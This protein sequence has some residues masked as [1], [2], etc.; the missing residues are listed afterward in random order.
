MA[1][2][3][4]IAKLRI[5][6]AFFAIM[7]SVVPLMAQEDSFV[8]FGEDYA[9][10]NPKFVKWL[11]VNKITATDYKD[12]DGGT[13]PEEFIKLLE[14]WKAYF[15]EKSNFYIRYPQ[16]WFTKLSQDQQGRLRKL[17]A[18]YHSESEKVDFVALK[19]DENIASCANNGPDGKPIGAEV[20]NETKDKSELRKHCSSGD[21]R[22][23]RRNRERYCEFG[24]SYNGN[25]SYQY[26]DNP[27]KSSD[28]TRIYDGEFSYWNNKEDGG[29]SRIKG[30][31]KMDK[32]VGQWSAKAYGY[33][34]IFNF[35][36]NGE[37]DGKFTF[38]K[39]KNTRNEEIVYSGSILN[40]YVHYIEFNGT[41]SRRKVQTKGY[42]GEGNGHPKR[43]WKISLNDAPDYRA[44]DIFCHIPQGDYTIQ[45]A[46]FK[47]G[48]KLYEEWGETDNWTTADGTTCTYIDSATGKR[49]DAGK[50]ITEIPRELSDDVVEILNRL[51]LR[52]SKGVKFSYKKKR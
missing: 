6:F 18:H 49:K 25:V 9:N 22:Y 51:I 3:R 10:I 14:I 38:Y 21:F 32:Q 26:I 27:D 13:N 41:W 47:D 44:S 1:Q 46:R 4:C 12:I 7:F 30:N 19:S 43:F 39:N 15:P 36:D 17:N 8:I 45:F 33:T 52:K 40:G 2:S 48:Y 42:Y 24:V 37:L 5:A 28:E 31:F 35:N 34:I 50:K 20:S 11:R 29:I 23:Y 16:G